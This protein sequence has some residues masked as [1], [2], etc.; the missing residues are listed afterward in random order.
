MNEEE[1]RELK[2]MRQPFNQVHIL[3]DQAKRQMQFTNGR[4]QIYK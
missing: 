2:D 3:T 4:M 1:E